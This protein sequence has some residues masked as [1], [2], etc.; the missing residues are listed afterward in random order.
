MD[1]A[2]A[3]GEANAGTEDYQTPKQD[4]E[5]EWIE[6]SGLLTISEWSSR[7]P[8]ASRSLEKVAKNVPGAI[9]GAKPSEW[10]PFEPWLT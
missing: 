5:Y 1:V 4:I 2:A 6:Q 8:S 10:D 7:P 9:Y 3:D